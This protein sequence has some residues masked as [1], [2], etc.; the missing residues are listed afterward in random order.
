MVLLLLFHYF[1]FK[2]FLHGKLPIPLA[3]WV[4]RAVHYPKLPFVIGT[5]ALGLRPSPYWSKIDEDVYLGCL[6][7]FWNQHLLSDLRV[8]AV[9]NMCDEA[10]GP[11]AF[12]K[13]S[14]IEQL[15][16]PTVDHIEP[17]VEDMKTAVQ[18]IDHNVQQG[19]KVLIHCM[20]GRGRSA[21]VAMAWLLYRF[22]QLDLDTAQQLLLSKRAMVRAK[23]NKQRNLIA[24]HS[25]LSSQRA[26][27]VN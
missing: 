11:A 7:T 23:L 5:F 6:P 8:R 19:K 2:P 21:A 1:I 20:A 16:L 14:G 22:R 9:V 24:Y 18:F 12:Y 10:Y 27:L 4:G 13:E 3:K 25:E 15:Y 17:T 26:K